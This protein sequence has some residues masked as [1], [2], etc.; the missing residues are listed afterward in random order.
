MKHRSKELILFTAVCSIYIFA[1]GYLAYQ[2]AVKSAGPSVPGPGIPYHERQEAGMLV[3]S[4]SFP[5]LCLPL[6]LFLRRLRT[7]LG[8]N[9]LPIIGIVFG[10]LCIPYY[11]V[12]WW[13]FG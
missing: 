3:G 11:F 7:W 1:A 2:L 12:L 8:R 5:L 10:I 13:L 6:L 9:P 4:I